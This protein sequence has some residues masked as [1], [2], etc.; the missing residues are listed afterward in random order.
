L[1]QAEQLVEGGGCLL[2]FDDLPA[3]LD[4]AHRAGVLDTAVGLGA[5][6]ILTALE[7]KELAVPAGASAKWFH[8]EQGA[9][10]EL[11]Q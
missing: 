10:S 8:V 2:L 4:A 3:E 6:V 7:P 11:I 5:Q 9:V 1:A